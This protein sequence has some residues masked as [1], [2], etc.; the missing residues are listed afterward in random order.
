M[1]SK[2]LKSTLLALLVISV[3]SCSKDDDNPN[4]GNQSPDSF[5]LITVP[6]GTTDVD[7]NP[8][9]SW[10][11]AIDP[12][13]DAL[14]YDVY[15]D[16]ENPP[17]TVVASDLSD[18]TYTPVDNLNPGDT[19]FW[20]VVA[21]DGN[22]GETMSNIASFTTVGQQPVVLD[23]SIITEATHLEDRGEGIDYIATCLLKVH[24]PLT[25]APG[26]TIAFEQGAG[27]HIKDYGD[28][29]GALTAVGTVDKPIVFT[30]TNQ[31]PGA[32]DRIYID[33]G[34][35][36]NK[37]H[38][39]IIEY[40]GDTDGSN[41]SL[42]AINGSKIE[43]QNTVIRNN[44]GDGVY[45]S[46]GAN[47]ENWSTNTITENQGYPLQIAA[48]KIKFLDGVQSVYA[49]NGT[50]QIY[51]NSGSIYNRGYIED[52]IG[53]PIHT[54]QNPGVP[55]FIDENIFV[56]KDREN[57]KPGHLKITEGCQIIFAEGYG[58]QT[59]DNNTVLQVLGTPDEK[60]KF[61]GQFGAGSWR[62]INIKE[63]NSNLNII[64]N[65][66]ISD[67]GESHWNW[68]THKGGLSLGTQTARII[69]LSVTNVHISNSAGCGIIERGV[70]EESSITYTNVT[71]SD[72]VGNDYC[73]E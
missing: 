20:A 12:D 57:E 34:D 60:V 15:L 9:F 50:N 54:W 58:I 32:W 5:N 53:G 2:N 30:G 4:P 8:T 41:P 22:Q 49:N 37:I 69:S 47:I 26:V 42:T 7:L 21:K 44:K 67:A 48:R 14:S 68:F 72:N 36:N 62:G 18:I 24:A 27:M 6:D 11:P 43:V 56:I 16:T 61:S 66:T 46:G 52:E 51:V 25:I 23:C 73:E 19:Y 65:T 29:T 28:L 3:F 10:E 71:F 63:S 70:K 13:G 59:S 39:S 40:A 45:V 31:I 35:L 17:A 64:E 38:H 1:N 55:Y 33:S